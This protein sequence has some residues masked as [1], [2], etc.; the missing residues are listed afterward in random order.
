MRA[1]QNNYLLD[2]VDNNNAQI[3]YQ[4]RQA[5]VVRPNVDAV[6]EFKVMTSAFSAEYGR[7]AGAVVNVNLKS[8]SNEI[9]GTLFEFLRNEKLDAKNFFDLPDQPRPPFKRNQYGFT[10][11]GPVKRNQTFFFG[12]YEWTKVRESRTVNNT[13][14]TPRMVNGDFS[15]LLPGTRIYDPATYDP[16][17]RQRQAFAGN[18]IPQ[19][20]LDPI[21]ARVAKLYP[22]PNKPGL[23]RNYLFNPADN[24]NRDRWDA[25]V[26]HN[27]G[28]YDVFTARYSYQRDYEPVSYSLP[29]PAFG[30]GGAD[31]G[32]VTTTG[33]N[34]MVSHNHVF[35]PTLILSAK[36]AWN[37]IFTGIEPAVDR[38]FNAELGIRGV[39]QTIPGMAALQPSGYTNVGIGTHLPNN[40]DSQNRQ[41]LADMTWL[42]SRHSVKFG[43]NF[44][45]KQGFLYNPQQAM[46]VFP[47]DGSFTRNPVSAREGNPIADLLLGYPFQAQTSNYA[48]MNQRAPFYDFYIQD[49][50][51]ATSRLTLNIG[52]RY[53]LHLPWV[54][55]RN[56]WANFDIDT[57]RANPQL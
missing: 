21:G 48:Y 14:P 22:E 32:D 6:Q 51:R 38:N 37:R 9:H 42:S 18:I 43:I 4:G 57:D 7:A 2:G 27:F 56:G 13:V 54:E 33:H 16:V 28:S 25:K 50:W 36:A 44:S 1:T 34:L 3:A 15:E 19:S 11:G 23:V 47:F 20:R 26:D 55:T 41:L 45:W 39:E 24:L 10:V 35:S 46:G 17:T 40:A 12:D 8:G 52:L 30:A 29:P 53:E 5:E 49:E 31:A